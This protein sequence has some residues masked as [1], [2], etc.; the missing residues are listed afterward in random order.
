MSFIWL[1]MTG[2]ISLNYSGIISVSH[3]ARSNPPTNNCLQFKLIHTHTNMHNMPI[4][5][6]VFVGLVLLLALDEM[7]SKYVILVLF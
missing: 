7:E 4:A 6:C 3:G 1:Q 2:N 5:R